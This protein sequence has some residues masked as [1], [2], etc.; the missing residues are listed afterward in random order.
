M[1]VRKTRTFFA[2]C[3]FLSC[4]IFFSIFSIN[5]EILP[6]SVCSFFF[7][8]GGGGKKGALWEICKWRIHICPLP[9]CDKVLGRIGCTCNTADINCYVVFSWDQ[10]YISVAKGAAYP[11]YQKMWQRKHI[12]I[13]G[14][15]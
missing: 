3:T 12:C 15:L 13:E 11:R 5:G 8:G 2:I 10:E 4:C 6:H 1:D 14:I 7:G 9:Q